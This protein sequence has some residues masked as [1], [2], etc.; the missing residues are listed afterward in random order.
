[1]QSARKNHPWERILIRRDAISEEESSLGE[2]FCWQ[3]CNQQKRIILG[4]EFLSAGMKSA[5]K[6]H[7]RKRIFIRRDEISE[8]ESSLGENSY[9][10]GCS[11][12]GRIIPGREFLSAGMKSAEKN[13]PWE[14]I[15]IGRDEISIA[16]GIAFSELPS[17]EIL[18]PTTFRIDPKGHW[19]AGYLQNKMPSR[20]ERTII[21]MGEG[22]A[23]RSL[24]QAR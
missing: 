2:N 24:L 20:A 4:R 7:P 23:F 19:R 17:G 13:H 14:R 21:R 1:M 10:Q 12:R 3:R 9:P 8:K 22:A 6:N 11:Q 5:R 16:E 18:N 15:L